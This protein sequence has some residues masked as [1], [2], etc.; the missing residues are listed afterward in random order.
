LRA[1][2]GEVSLLSRDG[3]V[4]I[5]NVSLSGVDRFAFS[6]FKIVELVSLFLEV[7]FALLAFVLPFA[8][9]SPP[10]FYCGSL[11]LLN[12]LLLFLCFL[13]S[14]LGN[15]LDFLDYL[16][17]LFDFSV[18]PLGLLL[19]LDLLFLCGI[20]LLGNLFDFLKQDD[21]LGFVL[22]GFD[23]C[24]SIG[25]V[26][27]CLFSNLDYVLM[28][29]LILPSV[30]HVSGCSVVEL[31]P[32]FLE[33]CF[34]F[35]GSCIRLE[36]HDFFADGALLLAFFLFVLLELLLSLFGFNCCICDICHLVC[37]SCDNFLLVSNHS[38]S[39]F[40]FLESFVLSFGL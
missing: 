16:L 8:D 30:S 31:L 35:D 3:Q 39:L 19:L 32:L 4:S 23:L 1:E 18:H 34:L 10:D 24:L 29:L 20:L 17:N 5:E 40:N 25:D 37:D 12:D 7:L 27:S 11:R 9:G 6:F 21:F 36:G 13:N 33:L 2:L 14:L 28:V 15:N 26:L 38:V 22:G